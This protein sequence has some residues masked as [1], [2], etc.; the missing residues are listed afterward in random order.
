MSAAPLY[1]GLLSGTSAD[2]IDAVLVRF[3]PQAEILA[4][5]STPYPAPLR[6]QLLRLTAP[7]AAISLD[8]FG[9]LD[10]AVGES[11]AAA[12]LDLL[13]GAGVDASAVHA[14]GSHGQTVRHRPDLIHPFSLQIGDAAVIAER[15]GICTVADFRRADVAAG[16]QGAP[17]VPALHAG[18]FA[19]F[20][21]CAVLNLGGIANLSLL[22]ADGQVLGFDT[23]PAN[24]LLDAWSERHLQQPCDMG[25]AWAASGRI[26]DALLDDLLQDPYFAAPTPKS[27]GREYFNLD[28]LQSRL[29]RHRVPAVDVQASLLALTARSVA[30]AL[31]DAKVAVSRV[32]V[33]GG[34][35]HNPILMQA[36]AQAMAPIAVASTASC[37]VDPDFIEATLF[38]WLAQERL[39]L[40]AGNLPAVTGARG[41]RVLGAVHA[42]HA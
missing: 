22:G 13:H 21:P 20:T 6:E 5:A 2:G 26:D 25:G 14:I 40:R 30:R 24:C 10:V 12:A 27:S 15:T 23:G 31:H 33:C 8:A 32:L 18:L 7:D 3:S 36:L 41:A 1:L 28:W 34:G 9:A 38:A 16:G 35:V 39:A 37:G 4:R 19:A 29:D 11:F 17:L 42:G